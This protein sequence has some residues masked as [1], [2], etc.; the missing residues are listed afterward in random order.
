MI[1]KNNK[2]DVKNSERD[3]FFFF[4]VSGDKCFGYWIIQL[5]GE[6]VGYKMISIWG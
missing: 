5:S 4:I 3:Y 2:Y 6:S 1:I